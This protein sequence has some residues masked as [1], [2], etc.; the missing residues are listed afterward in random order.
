LQ[1]NWLMIT[2][3]RICAYLFSKTKAP[4]SRITF[5]KTWCF[6]EQQPKICP[7]LFRL[8]KNSSKPISLTTRLAVG[9]TCKLLF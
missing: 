3:C 5:E 7:Y 1:G 2:L 6:T 8:V 9:L 4:S